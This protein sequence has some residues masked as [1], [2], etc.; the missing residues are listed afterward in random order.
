MSLGDPHDDCIKV[1]DFQS[2]QSFLNSSCG[3]IVND[4]K[5]YLVKSR[6]TPLLKQFNLGSFGELAQRL[7]ATDY[8]SYSLKEAVIDAMTTNE[9]YWFRDE[10][11]FN[12]LKQQIVP[13]L[14]KTSRLTIDIWS[15]ACSSGQE[16]YSISMSLGELPQ[17][18]RLQ[19]MATDISATMLTE[20]QNAVYSDLAMNRG[21]NAEQKMQFF[22]I[23]PQGYQVLPSIKQRVRFRSLNLMESFSS[24]GQFDIIFCRNVLIYFAEP[25]KQDILSRM[26]DCLRPGGV[27]FLSSTESMPSTVKSLQLV[28]GVFASYFKKID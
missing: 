2:I 3:L 25:A 7:G 24:L 9:T 13:A 18:K 17:Q 6:L 10:T 8:A 23:T 27:L 15:A 28:N 1:G 19:I 21:L 16:P 22:Q 26:A 12:E 4:S 14:C 20:A 11:Q 5:Q